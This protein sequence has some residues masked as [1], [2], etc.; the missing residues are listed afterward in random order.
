MWG[1]PVSPPPVK[2]RGCYF[3]T[4][5]CFL[6]RVVGTNSCLRHPREGKE[7]VPLVLALAFFLAGGGE[8]FC[9]ED[10]E[11]RFLRAL[12]FSWKIVL[13]LGVWIR[14]EDSPGHRSSRRPHPCWGSASAVGPRGPELLPG[15]GAC[16]SR[17]SGAVDG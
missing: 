3:Y 15:L 1:V 9:V 6:G 17:P 12:G 4:P 14:V 13:S 8:G 10:S 7:G 11:P 16:G 2:I 5:E